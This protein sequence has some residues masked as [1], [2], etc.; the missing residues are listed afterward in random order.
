MLVRAGL[1]VALDARTPQG[2]SGV[3][4]VAPGPQKGKFRFLTRRPCCRRIRGVRHPQM[5]NGRWTP[6]RTWACSLL[7]IF[8]TASAPKRKL[9]APHPRQLRGRRAW[10]GFLS[11]SSVVAALRWFRLSLAGVHCHRGGLRL[12]GSWRGLVAGRSPWCRSDR[13][14]PCRHRV[15]QPS[16]GQPGAGRYP[17][18]W[19]RAD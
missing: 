1:A 15:G 8:P 18:G 11:A 9:N 13:S 4:I 12:G 16:T 6:A 5:P 17:S 10:S 7:T 14:S 3:V 2:V 19:R